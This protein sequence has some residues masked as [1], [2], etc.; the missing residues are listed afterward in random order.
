MNTSPPAHHGHDHD[1][2]HHHHDHSHH[3]HDHIPKNKKILI[4]SFVLITI[5]ML[6]EFIGGYLTNSL[7]L[8]SDAGHMLSDSAALGIALAAI[9]IG[10]KHI[11]PKKSYGYQRFE[12][13]AAALNGITLIV[14]S[15]YI[16][17]EALLR[18]HAPQQIQI[19][20]MLIISSL[21]LFI[22]ISVAWIMFRGSDTTHD[23]N[24]RGAFLHVL[25]DLFG[26]IGAIIAALCIYYFNWTWADTLA[27]VLV[28]I[29]VLRSGTQLALKA[30]HILMQGTPEQFDLQHIAT[31]INRDPRIQG[32]HDLHIWSL[33]S[34]RYILSCHIVVDDLMSMQQVQHLLHQ[35]EQ[36]ILGLG[37]EHVTIQTETA[38]H[39]HQ[40]APFKHAATPH[41]HHS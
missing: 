31:L 7:A 1:H 35:I 4:C 2:S 28:A 9:Y 24:M 41:H 15:F 20:G 26:S 32:I 37:I 27:S 33:S 17:I 38:N 19:Q 16:F 13:L 10:Q 3:H 22:N 8:I 5:F 40:E 30:A 18:F 14:I 6:V 23:L 11:D 12:I 34:K 36:Q 21:G 39:L 25:S 29:L